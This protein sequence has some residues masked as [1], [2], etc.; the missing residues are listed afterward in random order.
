MCSCLAFGVGLLHSVDADMHT[1]GIVWTVAFVC[2]RHGSV[3]GTRGIEVSIN[4][5]IWN[6]CLYI[7]LHLVAHS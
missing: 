6:G 2:A 4:H 1:H 7:L 5:G 3:Y